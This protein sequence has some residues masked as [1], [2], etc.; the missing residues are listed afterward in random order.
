MIGISPVR[1]PSEGAS[2]L[3]RGLARR[4]EEAKWKLI[5]TLGRRCPGVSP[6]G[7]ARERRSGE[8]PVKASARTPWKGQAQGSIQRSVC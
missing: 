6:G 2:P 3:P 4:A 8:I 1:K 7:E 5:D